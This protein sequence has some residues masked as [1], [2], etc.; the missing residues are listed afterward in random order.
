[1]LAAVADHRRRRVLRRAARRARFARCWALAR[2]CILNA[3][4]S[5]LQNKR[6]QQCDTL[7]ANVK[8]A[9][10]HNEVTG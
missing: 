1:M 2:R 6:Q 4:L 9:Q 7:F 8:E 5:P 3:P 10:Q